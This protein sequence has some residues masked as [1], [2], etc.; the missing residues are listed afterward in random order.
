MRCI[1]WQSRSSRE[2][3]F[4]AG[5]TLRIHSSLAHAHPELS[6]N[7]TFLEI[8]APMNTEY[9]A[10]GFCDVDGCAAGAAYKTC[11]SLLDSLPDYRKA[12]RRSYEL[13]ELQ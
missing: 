11:L 13:L 6:A 2:R 3:R 7:P 12:K 5:T 4:P 1:S 9:L 8:G 10:T